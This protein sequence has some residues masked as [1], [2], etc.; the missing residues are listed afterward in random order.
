MQPAINV[1]PSRCLHIGDSWHADVE[2]ALAA[3]MTP[4]WIT[5][6]STDTRPQPPAVPRYPTVSHALRDLL[7]VLS[8]APPPHS[9]SQT[10]RPAPQH[11][12]HSSKSGYPTTRQEP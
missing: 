3:D 5:H 1:D 7:Q 12:P 8:P 4:I 10:T 6:P 2:G 9:L 11:R